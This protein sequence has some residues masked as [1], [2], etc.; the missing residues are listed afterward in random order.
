MFVAGEPPKTGCLA[1]SGDVGKYSFITRCRGVA[2][3]QTGSTLHTLIFFAARRG[4]RTA[5]LSSAFLAGTFPPAAAGGPSRAA[6]DG[7]FSPRPAPPFVVSL[8]SASTSICSI[9]ASER[10]PRHGW[11]P[12]QVW[13]SAFPVLF[14][15]EEFPGG[16]FPLTF[17]TQLRTPDSV[18]RKGKYCGAAANPTR[19]GAV[20]PPPVASG[21]KVLRDAR[22][23]RRCA[24]LASATP[25][26]L[27]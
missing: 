8:A 7:A 6:G 12:Q 24:A 9:C 17:C 16:I 26:G 23:G 21:R 1:A 4:V 25:V 22:L 2:D 15:R 27:C 14:V 10:L 11:R 5:R 20:V 13:A 19:A 18:P 3:R